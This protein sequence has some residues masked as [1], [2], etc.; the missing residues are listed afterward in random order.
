MSTSMTERECPDPEGYI[1]TTLAVIQVM[2]MRACTLRWGE[3]DTTFGRWGNRQPSTC[4]WA[5][6][7]IFNGRCQQV[8]EDLHSVYLTGNQ[9][10]SFFPSFC[11]C[12]HYKNIQQDGC[13]TARLFSMLWIRLWP[14]HEQSCFT[15][16]NIYVAG[17]YVNVLVFSVQRPKPGDRA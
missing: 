1:S 12:W 6:I 9:L 3:E 11:L 17:A 14:I 10:V 2:H 15:G 13:G 5:N 7:Y 16:K 8:I 4:F